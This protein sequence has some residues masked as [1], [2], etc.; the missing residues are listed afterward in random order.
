MKTF[1]NWSGG[2]DSALAFYKTINAGQSIDGLVTSVN[3]GTDRVSMHGIRRTLLEQQASAIG[4]PLHTIQLPEMPGMQAYEEAV[5]VKHKLLKAEGF[6]HGIFGDVFLE[7]LKRYRESLL[8]K[9]ELQ[10]LFPLWQMSSR[11]VVEEFLAA[12]F[13]AIIVCVNSSFLDSSFCGRMLDERF[14]ADLPS[15]VDPCGENGEYHSFVFDGPIFSQ[16]IRFTTGETVFKSYA[17][18]KKDD[19]FTAPQAETGF[20]FLDLL[21][22]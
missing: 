19:C 22:A 2:K 5:R 1:M 4:L 7:D 9:D 10:C 16:T 6:T 11:G 14:L 17:T 12:G 3:N 21:P 18:P 15:T 20:Y 8:A 13:K